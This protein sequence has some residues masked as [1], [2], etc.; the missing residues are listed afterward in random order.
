MKTSFNRLDVIAIFLIGFAV[1]L[2]TVIGLEG[3]SV[4]WMIVSSILTLAS[5]LITMRHQLF[6]D[7]NFKKVLQGGGRTN[8]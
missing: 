4:R 5:V 2:L 8:G 1:G 6:G 3:L 7:H